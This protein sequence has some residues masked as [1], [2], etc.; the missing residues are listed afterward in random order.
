MVGIQHNNKKY[1]IHFELLFRMDFFIWKL[2][3]NTEFFYTRYMYF[4]E[5][6]CEK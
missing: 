2:M 4:D 3:N 5:W 1:G 6:V